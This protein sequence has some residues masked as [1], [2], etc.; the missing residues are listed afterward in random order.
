MTSEEIIARMRS[1][2]NPE[3]VKGMARY[4]I[5]TERTLGLSMPTIRQLAKEI[6]KNH[7]LAEELWLSGIHEA[8][9]LASMVDRSKWVTEDQMERW[10]ADF[11]SWDVCDQVCM[12]LFDNTPYS[13][14]KA[15]EWARRPEEFVR[16]A[17]FAL[18]SALSLS[19]HKTDDSQL[20]EFMPI[21]EE[22]ASDGR[23]FV[24]K[25]A[26]WSLR[27]IGK[28]NEN[29]GRAAIETAE[30]IQ[31]QPYP[32]SRWIARDALRELRERYPSLSEE[33]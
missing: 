5:N 22:T 24:K 19:R 9:H 18:M 33:G 7:E 13:F 2:A 21:I 11:D 28:R 17:G 25:A 29:L 32:S 16:R 3:W 31:A 12:H 14:E 8:R 20:L 10:V 26:N 15:K 23:N 30:R 27:Q 1:M 6:P 4:A